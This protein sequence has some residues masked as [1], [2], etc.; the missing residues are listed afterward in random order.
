MTTK[1]YGS[2]LSPFVRHCRI[3]FAQE[4]LEYE[5]IEVDN[6]TSAKNSPTKKVPYLINEDLLLSDSSSIVKYVREKSGK[7]F[8]ADIHDFELF[9]M[10]NT[11][12][13][14]A[15]NLFLLEKSNVTPDSVGYLA[16]QQS[17]L[18][19]GLAELNSRFDPAKGLDTDSAI[20]CVCFI[21]WALFRE[22]IH[23]DG[24]D[25]LI[26]LREAAAKI[27]AFASTAPA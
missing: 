26:A 23:I 8:L 13:D 9:T 11:L 7:T 12:V 20:R 5:F 27:D 3:A 25:N 21:D 17:R 16:R 19:D 10:T 22:R 14:S 6:D 1:L 4:Q 24:L 18:N 2:L 15:L